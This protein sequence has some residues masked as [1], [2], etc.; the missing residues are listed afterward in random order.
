M[1]AF[2]ECA[3]MRIAGFPLRTSLLAAAAGGTG[4]IVTATVVY[5]LMLG[6]EPIQVSQSV[7][8]GVLGRATYQGGVATALLGL[9]LHYLIAW[10]AASAYVLA[11]RR[12]PVLDRRPLLAGAG[13]GIAWYFFMQLVV[14]PL[15]AA[16]RGH[17]TLALALVGI[18]IH[19]LAFGMPIAF[20]THR[21]RLRVAGACR[22]RADHP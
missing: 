18:T 12:W 21:Q 6:I 4:D 1:A 13:F 3:T 2:E 14:L 15:S 5:P 17:P 19:S 11:A 22:R 10:G 16:P 7:A 20:V 8:S 9:A